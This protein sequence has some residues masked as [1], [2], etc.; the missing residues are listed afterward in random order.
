[1]TDVTIEGRTRA[2]AEA[3]LVAAKAVG[4]EVWE[5]RTSFKGYVVPEAVAEEYQRML[6]GDTEPIADEEAPE[7]DAFPDDS[8]T[9]ADIR[10]YAKDNE[11]P[12]PAEATKKADILAVVQS[13]DTKEE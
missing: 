10:A 11:I 7:K 8:W 2:T 3:L 9:V 12:I 13:A 6:D 5:V 1:M 4:A